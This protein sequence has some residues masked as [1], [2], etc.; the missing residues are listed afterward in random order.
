M[1][2]FDD[3]RVVVG[4]TRET[5]SGFD[6]RVTAAGQRHVLANALALAP[7]LADA[8]LIETRVGLRP[9]SDDGRPIVGELEEGLYLAAGYGP[10]GLTIAPYTGAQIAELILDG[11]SSFDL[12]PFAPR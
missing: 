2:A 1:V 12:S 4:A 11:G 5:G 6:R 10:I 7:G 9:L 3:S 8:T